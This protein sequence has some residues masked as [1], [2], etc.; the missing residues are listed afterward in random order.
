MENLLDQL[1]VLF[2]KW[3]LLGFCILA[4]VGGIVSYIK[5]FES[6]SYAWTWSDHFWSVIRRGFMGV[7][8]GLMVYFIAATY[9]QLN[10]P[11]AFA[12]AGFSG[13]FASELFEVI[14]TIVRRKLLNLIPRKESK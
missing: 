5:A 7:F 9:E 1:A 14:W 13:I 4:M 10:S 2:K 8:A 11:M 12:A 3:P 6:S